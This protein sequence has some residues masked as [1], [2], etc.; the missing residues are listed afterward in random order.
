MLEGGAVV[1]GKVV[2][3]AESVERCRLKLWVGEVLGAA[4]GLPPELNC[5]VVSAEARVAEAEVGQCVGLAWAA[6]RLAVQREGDAGVGHCLGMLVELG[7]HQA[8]VGP[9]CG[10]ARAAEPVLEFEGLMGVVESFGTAAEE[11]QVDAEVAL[12]T[13]DAGAIVE[14][15]E[16]GEGRLVVIDGLGVPAEAATEQA[17]MVQVNRLAVA[18]AQ[19]PVKVQTSLETAKCLPGLPGRRICVAEVG[20]RVCQRAAIVEPTRRRLGEMLRG[21]PIPDTAASDEVR[22]Q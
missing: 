19:P 9:K 21:N 12:R 15:P 1:A 20:E 8:Q 11:V 2:C 16:E 14:H 17:E 10:L 18:V 3:L 5:F 22:L 13:G 6:A 4:D 7:V